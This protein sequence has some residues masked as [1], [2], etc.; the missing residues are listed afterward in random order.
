MTDA[1]EDR[2]DSE[3]VLHAK[4]AVVG[5]RPL[6]F[7]ERSSMDMNARFLRAIDVDYFAYQAAAHRPHLN[8]EN[9]QRAAIAIRTTYAHALETLFA[10][11]G[12]ALQTPDSPAG[13]LLSYPIKQLADL[14]RC[15]GSWEPFPNLQGLRGG[16]WDSVAEALLPWTLDDQAKQVELL[17]TRSFMAKALARFG[18]N[19]ADEKMAAEYNSIKHGL[20]HASSDWYLAIG[21]E[22]TPGI[23]APAER[24]RTMSSSE[25]GGSFLRAS[26]P[27]DKPHK[28]HIVFSDQRVNWNPETLAD[29]IPFVAA[30][31][32]NVVSYLRLRAGEPSDSLVFEVGDDTSF[33]RVWAQHDLESST[34]MSINLVHR[35]DVDTSITA[36]LVRARYDEIASRRRRKRGA[37]DS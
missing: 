31:L 7:W 12:A 11:V 10:F 22:D 35:D 5:T 2:H 18:R 34:R 36:D 30:C 24:M 16:G 6:C 13:W 15:V 1:T 8:G 28:H 27:L 33:E 17:E 3:D 9:R 25:F 26:A 37:S 19:F 32:R 4:V 20:R 21:F 29:L 23:A 14:V